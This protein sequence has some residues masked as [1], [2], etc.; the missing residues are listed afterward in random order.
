MIKLVIPYLPCSYNKIV[1][2][3]GWKRQEYQKRWYDELWLCWRYYQEDHKIPPLPFKKAKV[4]FTVY[5]PDR[6]HRDKTNIAGG[7]KFCL[8]ALTMRGVGIIEDDE[9]YP[10]KKCD[11]YYELKYDKE[12]PRTVIEIEEIK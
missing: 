9:N 8:D 10:S 6:R 4:T 5:F 7:L 2:F 11:D 12:H 1:K 3:S